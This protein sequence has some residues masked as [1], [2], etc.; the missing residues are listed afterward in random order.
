MSLSDELADWSDWDV[1]SSGLDR[2]LG[3]FAAQDYYS[4]KSGVPTDNPPGNGLHNA[5]LALAAPKCWSAM[6][7]QM[8]NSGS[9]RRVSSCQ[10]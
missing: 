1:A 4:V 5:L 7:N 9:A 3:V 2:A 10:V 6:R 8:S